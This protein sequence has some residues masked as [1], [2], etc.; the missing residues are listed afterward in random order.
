MNKSILLP[1]FI[2]L[3]TLNLSAQN[4]DTT[5]Y[6][7]MDHVRFGGGISMAFGSGYSSFSIAPS[8]IYDF[9]QYF[10]AGL[11][12]KYIY[13]KQKST[14]SKAVNMYGGSVLAFFRPIAQLQF[15]TEYERI[16]LN[17]RINLQNAVPNSLDAL[18]FGIEYVTGN[19]AIG[20]RYNVLYDKG[21]DDIIYPSAALPVFRV[22][23]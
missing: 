15:S 16:K 12:G 5:P 3:L 6:R 20:F 22:Y 14:V 4:N 21:T 19:I 11:A 9:S 2:L 23:F 10:S 8:A 1:V 17:E 13:H 18:F 7:F